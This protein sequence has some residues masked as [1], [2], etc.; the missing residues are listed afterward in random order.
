M[1]SAGSV[2]F[3]IS[4]NASK[5]LFI[6][7]IFW[8]LQN[9]EFNGLIQYFARLISNCKGYKHEKTNLFVGCASR[10]IQLR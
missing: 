4:R 2:Y 10:I 3:S 5:K 8:G 9:K 1:M 6:Y 7:Y